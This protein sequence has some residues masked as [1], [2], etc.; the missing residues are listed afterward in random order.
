MLVAPAAGFL[1][2][3]NQ[4]NGC[5]GKNECYLIKYTDDLLATDHQ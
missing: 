5:Q 2:G 4:R 1:C 3:R